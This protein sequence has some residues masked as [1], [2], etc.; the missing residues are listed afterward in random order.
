MKTFIFSALAMAVMASC[1][2]SSI[3]E[4]VNNDEPVAI[5]LGAGVQT[6]VVAGTRAA[7]T[8]DATF[9][10]IVLGWE[11]SAAPESYAINTTWTS[12]TSEIKGNATSDA[13]TLTP[14]QYYSSDAGTATYMKAFYAKDATVDANK[15]YVYTFTSAGETDVLMAPA[16][17]GDKKT[18]AT[19]FAFVH[20]LMQLKF[21]LV[22]GTGF[23]SGVTVTSITVKAAVLPNG[24]D[25]STDVVTYADAADLTVPG[26]TAAA[27][28]GSVVGNPVMV[29]PFAGGTFKVDVVAGNVTYTDVPV[30]LN[31]FTTGAGVAYTVTLTFQNKEIEGSAKVTDWTTGTGSGTVE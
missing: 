31:D 10:A 8:G 29:K 16:I 19:N 3:D 2:N 22:A 13:I 26:I 11:A 12:T 9:N 18:P 30:T 7:I 28:N 14:K 21:V 24:V 15:S 17:N 4:V 25:M 27:I 1:T 5:R 20:P 6:N 23:P